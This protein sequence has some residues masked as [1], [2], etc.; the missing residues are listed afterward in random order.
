MIKWWFL[1]YQTIEGFSARIWTLQLIFILEV[2]YSVSLD[3]DFISV[4]VKVN[5]DL[6]NNSLKV[7]TDH[8]IDNK[9]SNM[10]I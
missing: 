8:I 7:I 10:R 5:I 6:S 2:W 9:R 3:N 4:D 1:Y